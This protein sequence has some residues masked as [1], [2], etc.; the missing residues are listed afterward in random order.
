[1]HLFLYALKQFYPTSPVLDY[2]LTDFGFS[3]DIALPQMLDENHRQ[4]IE[5]RI[6]QWLREGLMVQ[7][8]EMMRDN[9]ERM[10]QQ[11]REFQRVKQVKQMEEDVIDLIQIED[12]F[13]PLE[14]ACGENLDE[15][16]RIS[17]LHIEEG[18]A[19]KK[20]WHIVGRGGNAKG[21][22]KAL[23]GETFVQKG[24]ESGI[25]DR[26]GDETWL[27]EK[28]LCQLRDEIGAMRKFYADKGAREVRSSVRFPLDIHEAAV[29]KGAVFELSEEVFDETVKERFLLEG[30]K[31]LFD[32]ATFR[33]DQ[34]GIATAQDWVR[35]WYESRGIVG[36]W[37]YWGRGMEQI[38]GGNRVDEESF[39]VEGSDAGGV[40]WVR[41][42]IGRRWPMSVVF[43]RNYCGGSG[44][45]MVWHCSLVLSFERL[46]GLKLMN[47]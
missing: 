1:M 22:Y 39:G 34:Q 4:V 31:N 17:I 43:S 6:Q 8:V 25:F 29:G 7:R 14:S 42:W 35:A 18:Q 41:D 26:V 46:I 32:L 44:A 12:Y 19:D 37:E 16:H 10:F 11:K 40:F 23:N 33:G 36:E 21:K 45:G 38:F 2:G 47:S 5:E 20:V 24:K 30:R 15:V 3:V 28:G 27:D 13:G 9:A